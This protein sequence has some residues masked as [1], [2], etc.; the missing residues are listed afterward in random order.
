MKNW[1][2]KIN[3][4]FT[5]T[6][7]K[8][9][10]TSRKQRGFTLV[11]SLVS[12]AIFSLAMTAIIGSFLAVLRINEKSRAIRV[13]EQNARFI[14]EYLTR[15]VRNGSIDYGSYVAY[16]ISQPEDELHLINSA[17]EMITISLSDGVLQLSKVGVGSSE[18]SNSD[19]IVSDVD[20][21]I[22]PLSLPFCPDPCPNDQP[23]VT[24]VMTLTS[25]TNVR[26]TD[27]TTIKLQGTVSSRQYSN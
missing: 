1:R 6:P 11:E 10:E 15:E 4:R 2:K 23:R 27:Q 17:G 5:L 24:F 7:N 12:V 21:Y 20:F 13:V 3:K 19:I 14:T 16:G 9:G 25:N 26:P 22:Y 8:F 18:L